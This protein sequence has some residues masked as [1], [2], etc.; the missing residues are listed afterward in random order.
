MLL[1][2][3]RGRDPKGTC[4]LLHGGHPPLKTQA[5]QDGNPSGWAGGWRGGDTLAQQ[6]LPSLWM[7]RSHSQKFCLTGRVLLFPLQSACSRQPAHLSPGTQLKGFFVL[8]RRAPGATNSPRLAPAKRSNTMMG[9]S[10]FPLRRGPGRAVAPCQQL[11][12]SLCLARGAVGKF[13]LRTPPRAGAAVSDSRNCRFKEQK[14]RP[15]DKRF[16]SCWEICRHPRTSLLGLLRIVYW[17]QLS[18]SS[19]TMGGGEERKASFWHSFF[20]VQRT[21]M[22]CKHSA[23]D[24]VKLKEG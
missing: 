1:R 9:S 17:L 14:Q 2:G 4:H 12:P 24:N 16:C 5:Q 3:W 18:K 23:G 21:H 11:Q 13:G 22:A 20:R 6:L 19:S 10:T 15:S 7:T 8:L